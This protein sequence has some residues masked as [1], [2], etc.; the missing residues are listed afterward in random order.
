[1]PRIHNPALAKK[2]AARPKQEKWNP[3]PGPYGRGDPINCYD[4]L[5][6]GKGDHASCEKQK[7]TLCRCYRGKHQ[8]PPP[9]NRVRGPGHGNVLTV[10]EY[11][12]NT[13][14]SPGSRRSKKQVPP[15]EPAEDEDVEWED[16]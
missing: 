1:M 5:A 16:F 3:D 14:V 8:S 12:D 11:L 7:L 4:C 15:P 13:F 2:Y 10:D 9:K 6:C